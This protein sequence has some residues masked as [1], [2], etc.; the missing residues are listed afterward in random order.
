MTREANR[1][2]RPRRTRA[3]AVIAALAALALAACKKEGE[4]PPE[5]G[6]RGPAVDVATLKAPALF[7][8]IPAD[9]PYVFAS[10]EAVPLEYYAKIRRALGPALARSLDQI[11]QLRSWGGDREADRWL[12]AVLDELDGKWSAKGLESLGLSAQPRFAIY[13]HG[14]LPIVARVEIKDGKALLATIERIAHRAGAQLPPLENRHGREFWRIELPGDA[15]AIVTIT[16]DELVTAYGPRPAIAAVLPQIL[17]AEQPS[18]NMAGGEEL[19][20]LIAKHRLGPLLIGYVDAKRLASSAIAL[21]EH[22]PPAACTAEIDRLAAQVPRL[23][24]GYTEL[25]D[26]RF[27]GAAIVELA[28]PLVEELKAL[29]VAVPGLRTALEGEPLLAVGGGLDLARG[30]EAGKSLAATL[31]DLGIACDAQELVRAARKLRDAIAEPL[32]EPLAKVAGAAIRIDS[33]DFGGGNDNGGRAAPGVPRAVEGVAMIAAP[34]ARSVLAALGDKLRVSV[35]ADGKLHP[36]QL[37]ELGLPFELHGGV[38]AQAIVVAAGARGKQQAEKVLAASAN[39]KAP[40]LAAKLDLAKLMEL[41]RRLDPSDPSGR[42]LADLDGATAA[43]FGRMMFHID[44]T[45]AGLALWMSGD[46]K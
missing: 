31:R 23:V 22:A 34:D 19:K 35:A 41:Q 40:L 16:G 28:P 17:G 11:R 44:A 43:L 29:R 13:G 21:A 25:T 6:P 45:D 15:G 24:M 10:F 46:L 27:S 26:K 5:F 36:I 18:R 37:A 4:L 14:A 42:G 3:A 32:P 2:A 20:R 38:G 8:H 7:A 30:R 12:D 1:A 33:V 9:A 39:D